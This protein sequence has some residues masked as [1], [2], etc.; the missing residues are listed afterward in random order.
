ML[1][2]ILLLLNIRKGITK[3]FLHA[4]VWFQDRQVTC[5]LA[6]ARGTETTLAIITTLLVLDSNLLTSGNGL[7][8]GHGTG[9]CIRDRKDLDRGS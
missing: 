8:G 5:L 7:Y 6:S 4:L 1:Q 3:L 2:H 9:I